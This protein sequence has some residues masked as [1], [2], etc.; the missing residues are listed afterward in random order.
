MRFAIRSALVFIAVTVPLLV[1]PSCSSMPNELEVKTKTPG[2]EID[3]KWK[4]EGEP[5]PLPPGWTSTSN[6]TLR[7]LIDGKI[8]LVSIC[9]AQSETNPDCIFANLNGCNATDGWQMYCKEV[10]ATEGG[11]PGTPGGAVP[12]EPIGVCPTE[13][14]TLDY[15]QSTGLST[16]SFV[17][18]C[19]DEPIPSDLIDTLFTHPS[20]GAP[21]PPDVFGL[22]TGGI[23]PPGT[24][25]QMAGDKYTIAWNALL[26][27][28][29]EA[30]YDA[31]TGQRIAVGMRVGGVAHP[32]VA[33]VVVNEQIVDTFFVHDPN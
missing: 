20:G 29:T 16:V 1:V 25:V 31:I 33:V 30:A 6:R 5:T 23:I 18:D 4:R 26:L 10:V 28:R 11:E 32:P 27:G 15:S 24:I 21:V 22:Q 3:I 17:T 19:G 9:I 8:Y 2:F 7:M 13:Y 12:I 14:G